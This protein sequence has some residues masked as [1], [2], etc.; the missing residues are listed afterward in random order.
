MTTRPKE[1]GGM[2]TLGTPFGLKMRDIGEVPEVPSDDGA[3]CA[4][5]R[6]PD[7]TPVDRFFRETRD[8][9]PP[10][11]EKM[12]A[13][14][15]CKARD[16]F[17]LKVGL[18]REEMKK[19]AA[20]AA[21]PVPVGHVLL[22]PVPPMILTKEER[23]DGATM[24]K[25]VRNYDPVESPLSARNGLHMDNL[26]QSGEDLTKE[27]E[28]FPDKGLNGSD[29]LIKS[30][31][32][33][34]LPW[35]SHLV[36][37]RPNP[38]L[39]G[40]FF[41]YEVAMK[42]WY[43][44]VCA[45]M[46]PILSSKQVGD[47]VGLNMESNREMAA[48]PPPNHLVQPPKPL[49]DKMLD[50][51]GEKKI[52]PLLLEM[53]EDYAKRI[54]N[55]SAFKKT[56]SEKHQERR[57][58]DLEK[59]DRS[60]RGK[61][62]PSKKRKR[63]EMS[64]SRA[65]RPEHSKLTAH[66][67]ID[68]MR[69]TGV[70]VAYVSKVGLTNAMREERWIFDIGFMAK[71]VIMS[72]GNREMTKSEEQWMPLLTAPPGEGEKTNTKSLW[73]FVLL[74][75]SPK[76]F[77]RAL[78]SSMENGK[79]V[80]EYLCEQLPLEEVV[81][82][83]FYS[84]D[85]RF[86]VKMSVLVQYFLTCKAVQEK[87][88]QLDIPSLERFVELA[89]FTA[90]RL[91]QLEIL[92]DEE[93]TKACHDDP[94]RDS[95]IEMF[96]TN[97]RQ[98][99][100]LHCLYFVVISASEHFAKMIGFMRQEN[101]QSNKGNLLHRSYQKIVEICASDQMFPAILDGFFSPDDEVHRFY[102]RLL[103]M[104]FTFQY[105]KIIRVI[106]G[107]DL[108]SFMQKGINSKNAVIRRH[109][110]SLWQLIRHSD[111]SLVFQLQLIQAQPSSVVTQI[112]SANHD[113]A[114]F[115]QS[116]FSVF[117]T[118]HKAFDYRPLP[119]TQFQAFFNA[120][121]GDFSRPQY[122]N[123]LYTLL[124]FCVQEESLYYNKISEKA[125]L[126]LLNNF[127]A[128]N[129]VKLIQNQSLQEMNLSAHTIATMKITKMKCLRLLCR[130]SRLDHASIAS[131]E[132]WTVIL[133]KMSSKLAS[134]EAEREQAWKIFR[135]A[136]LYQSK[137]VE[138]ILTNP[139]LC[140]KMEDAF[141][142]LDSGVGAEMIQTLEKLAIATAQVGDGGKDDQSRADM[143]NLDYLWRKLAEPTVRI[144]GKILSNYHRTD[145]DTDSTVS[146]FTAPRVHS[147][148][149]SM[150]KCMVESKESSPLHHFMKAEHILKELSGVFEQICHIL[151]LSWKD[152]QQKIQLESMSPGAGSPLQQVTAST[153]SQD[154]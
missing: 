99:H 93:L 87:L 96:A 63:S 70:P 6:M 90:S 137:F 43:K 23:D 38:V 148:V 71:E 32:G 45:N 59:G 15:D 133:T 149:V 130:V 8:S 109:A 74:D 27:G 1:L 131:V 106:S 13:P 17:A 48:P 102:Y 122:I 65:F 69:K 21:P 46:V 51:E 107:H 104:T 3:Q 132:I 78:K 121:T 14:G 68:R 126:G 120:L 41:E 50:K 153:P 67:I 56:K 97:F 85:D 75:W 82:M 84:L 129:G 144:T 61:R 115:L 105:T 40:N 22:R 151:G 150:L 127:T 117:R 16:E 79:K 139:E 64:F 98:A 44:A 95:Q 138:F 9:F 124:R 2:T 94:S 119:F 4:V 118:V 86:A 135:N 49:H 80:G 147:S 35:S 141:S 111:T 34:K 142:S 134:D 125:Y 53:Q 55:A 10:F 57:V 112:G 54:V 5:F 145:R 66:E 103:R 73:K 143:E 92:P 36:P 72:E 42:N 24:R 26:L 76:D 146:N 100:M 37:E 89:T 30:H 18:W 60:R 12:A 77:H 83:S 58:S 31:I 123:F 81:S 116:I 114:R 128:R 52:I 110:L 28:N 47:M 25:L 29:V 154:E 11:A 33:E 108:L 7:G 62:T 140:K 88:L 19:S 39:F 152:V 136:V 91:V 101:D 113:S 20:V